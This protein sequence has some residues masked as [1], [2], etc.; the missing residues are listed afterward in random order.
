M[1]HI[2]SP[3]ELIHSRSLIPTEDPCFT[4]F[5]ISTVNQVHMQTIRPSPL[6]AELP[7]LSYGDFEACLF[8]SE[9]A[10]AIFSQC[11]GGRCAHCGQVSYSLTSQMYHIQN[12]KNN[13]PGQL[14]NTVRF[15]HRLEWR[16]TVRRILPGPV[17]YFK[18]LQIALN[19]HSNRAA[20]PQPPTRPVRKVADAPS[21][22]CLCPRFLTCHDGPRGDLE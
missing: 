7:L 20:K 12:G 13:S 10:M 6:S 19:W 21:L 5:G 11:I 18:S 22:T 8:N 3:P 1:S 4:G 17:E 15:S 14:I 2:D 9:I 16:S